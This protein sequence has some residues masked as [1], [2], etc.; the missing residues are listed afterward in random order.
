MAAFDE[1]KQLLTDRGILQSLGQEIAKGMA[2]AGNAPS[3]SSFNPTG[4]ARGRAGGRGD[5]SGVSLKD[6][7]KA[8][9][10]EIRSRQAHSKYTNQLTKQFHSLNQELRKGEKD[11]K[12]AQRRTI[13]FAHVFE[14][15]WGKAMQ[16][17]LTSKKSEDKLVSRLNSLLEEEIESMDDVLKLRQRQIRLEKII[18]NK[19]GGASQ[20]ILDEHAR[21][22]EA[23]SKSTQG[24]DSWT[25]SLFKSSKSAVRAFF[26]VEA[27]LLSL[28][29]AT[30]QLYSDYKT[31]LKFG[32]QFTNVWDQQIEAMKSGI[33]PGVMAELMA[34][35]RQASLTFDSLGGYM[36]TLQGQQVKYYNQIGDLTQSLKFG[37]DM[38][39]LLGKS[40]IK[41]TAAG[42]DALGGTFRVL[43]KIAGVTSDQFTQMMS[44]TLA[45][46]DIQTR[47]RAAK[48]G[49]RTAIIQGIAKQIEMN[50]AM[51]LTTEQAMGAAVAMGK[52]AGGGA[53]ERYKRAAQ[54]QMAMGAMGL[55]GGAELA[56]LTRKGQ[57]RFRGDDAERFEILSTRLAEAGT[58]ARGGDR[59]AEFTRDAIF[60]N[61]EDHFGETSPF[62]KQLAEG[63]EIDKDT[64][65]AIREGIKDEPDRHMKVMM[66]FD[67]VT[68]AIANSGIAKGISGIF[69]LGGAMALGRYGGGIMSRMLGGGAGAGAG[70]GIMAG[71]GRMAMGGMRALPVV[72]SIAMAGKDLYDLSQGDTSG[73]NTGAL[74]GTAAGAVI[75]GVLGSIIP[76]AGTV[77]G[78]GLGASAGNFLGEMVGGL[79]DDNPM[80]EQQTALTNS[81]AEL[82]H[83]TRRTADGVDKL[84][85]V[86]I[87][88]KE[89]TELQIKQTAGMISN[90]DA[91]AR[92]AALSDST[93]YPGWSKADA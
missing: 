3:F 11:M 4:E 15:E 43:N 89:L 41:P 18:L 77:I 83:P 80:Q 10:D 81:A 27:G 5:V 48:K 88:Q 29:V 82:V 92:L 49:E 34:E 61:L 91:K 60:R 78:A 35:T 87:Q 59:G 25:S 26:S 93:Q 76:G 73:A 30:K 71:A 23:M 22:S 2:S 37:T 6:Q 63:L 33:D 52:I 7:R 19:R 90:A 31:Q 42:M 13:A 21:I 1:F 79:F 55:Q 47:L 32:S 72:G 69:Q 58:A 74:V 44:Q 62:N 51:G 45:D 66:G 84:I 86:N 57:A 8:Q 67:R 17:V 65:K 12:S 75:G 56:D 85:A 38:F 20:S 70:G 53:K 24:I 68:N 39:H 9:L 64:L 40:G 54:I 28:L 16:K 46:Q 36:D 50:V 14:D